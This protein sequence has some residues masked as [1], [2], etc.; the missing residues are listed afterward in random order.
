MK[1][2]KLCILETPYAGNIEDN[3]EYA[4]KCMHD[5]LLRKEAPYASHLLYTQP[6]VLDD[7]VPEDRD[8][9][10]YAGFAWKHL[11]GVHTVFYTDKGISKGMELALGYC[12]ENN[13]SYEFRSL[14]ESLN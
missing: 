10:I 8:L 5:M 4:Q 13:M 11:K 2:F 6:N 9:G 14:E 7:S 3:V 12:K 1:D